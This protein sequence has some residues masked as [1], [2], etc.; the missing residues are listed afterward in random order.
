MLAATLTLQ[1]PPLFVL[2]RARRGNTAQWDRPHACLFM[3]D[4][5]TQI[6]ELLNPANFNVHLAN[7]AGQE[8]FLA[9][10]AHLDIFQK[11]SRLR[12]H[13]V[14]RVSMLL[15]Y[16]VQQHAQPFPLDATVVLLRILHAPIH[17]PQEHF[18]QVVPQRV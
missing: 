11:H 8:L 4:A 3:Q 13:H 1:L 2:I 10:T 15:P 9:A 16:Q 18:R 17:V 5:M 6:L 7:L 14:Q 12:A